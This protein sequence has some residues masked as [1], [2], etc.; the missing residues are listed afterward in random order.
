MKNKQEHK[1]EKIIS[2]LRAIVGDTNVLTGDNV[3]S[4]MIHVWYNKP[5]DA[6]CIVR[7]STTQQVSQI[8]ALC[9]NKQQQITPHGGLTGL[10]QGCNVTSSDVVLSLEKMKKII[11]LDPIGRTMTVE[12]GVPLQTLQEEAEKHGLMFPL[13]L[14]AR[15]SC[16]IGGNV[17]TNAGGNR[18]IRFGMTRENILG[19]EAVLPNGTVITSLNTMIKN[20]AGYD[21]KQLFIGSEGTLGIVTKIVVRLREAPKFMHTGIAA[22]NDFSQLSAFLRYID[23]ELGGALSAFEVMW[24]D[25]YSLV[26][27]AP[28][29][30][31]KPIAEDYPYYALFE[32]LGSDNE[33]EASMFQGIMEKSLENNLISDAVIAKSESERL[34]MWKLRDSVDEW[35]RYGPVFIYDVSLGIRHMKEYV[36]TVKQNLQKKWPNYKCFTVGHIGDGNIHFAIHV[37]GD[38]DAEHRA[39]NDC[40]YGPLKDIGGSVSAEHGIGVEKRDYLSLSRTTAEIEVMRKIKKC[41]DPN[42]IL[43]SSKIFV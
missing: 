20:N 9:D 16:Q 39:V 23:R 8:L 29:T 30:N 14:G 32:A 4:R 31:K 6:L 24:N 34:S 1:K 41:L 43:N 22:F 12:A 5:I 28:A 10:V 21:L 42:N 19:L 38:T 37:G 26:T 33:T 36:K 35:F 7:P 13:D 15:G 18:V 17:S 11:E 40:V 27:S 2:N 3:K 25:Y